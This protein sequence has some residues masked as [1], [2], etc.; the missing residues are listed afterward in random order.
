MKLSRKFLQA[1]NH[2]RNFI[3]YAKNHKKSLKIKY[4][5]ECVY[6]LNQDWD[7]ATMKNQKYNRSIFLVSQHYFFEF[8]RSQFFFDFL[9]YMKCIQTHEKYQRF[10]K[11]WNVFFYDN[12]SDQ[13]FNNYCTVSNIFF[14]IDKIINEKNIQDPFLF[15]G[16]V[17]RNLF[18]IGSHLVHIAIEYNLDYDSP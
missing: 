16:N 4:D 15:L 18:E 5:K 10:F 1:Y 7:E 9:K 3:H 13:L 12:T 6:S 8:L 11:L 2:L 17:L 14:F